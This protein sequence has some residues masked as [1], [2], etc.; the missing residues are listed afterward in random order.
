MSEGREKKE[1][2]SEEPRSNYQDEHPLATRGTIRSDCGRR[3]KEESQHRTSTRRENEENE[4]RLDKQELLFPE[5]GIHHLRP[6]LDLLEI[7]SFSRG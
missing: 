2:T 1:L 7:Q 6:L 3:R 4:H 5:L